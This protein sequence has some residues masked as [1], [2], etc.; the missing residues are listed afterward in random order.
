[1]RLYGI[2][3]ADLEVAMSRPISTDIDKKDNPRL[4]G[5]DSRGRA[6]IVVIAGNDQDFV[7]TTF[8]AD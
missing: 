5:V 4:T 8:P 7:I 1:M 2:S 3:R 6:I